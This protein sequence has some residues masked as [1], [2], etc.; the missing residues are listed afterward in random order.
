MAEFYSNSCDDELNIESINNDYD[1]HYGYA[2]EHLTVELYIRLWKLLDKDI[3]KNGTPPLC[4]KLLD[5]A[6]NGWNKYMGNVDTIRKI[7]SF[8]RLREDQIQNLGFC[9][10]VQRSNTCYIKHFGYTCILR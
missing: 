7:L 8:I 9:Y 4:R 5:A 2:Q 6:T 3:V 10:G 1:T